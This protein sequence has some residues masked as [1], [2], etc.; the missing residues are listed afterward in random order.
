MPVDTVQEYAAS[1]EYYEEAARSAMREEAEA[2]MWVWQHAMNLLNG[3]E[4]LR[5]LSHTLRRVLPG[6]SGAIIKYKRGV[7]WRVGSRYGQI[8]YD[9]N[10][11]TR[12]LQ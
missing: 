3:D 8:M 2:M 10:P 1:A 12:W 5:Q 9:R 4:G 11:H 6:Y 7:N